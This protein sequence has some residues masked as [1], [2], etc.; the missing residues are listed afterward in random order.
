MFDPVAHLAHRQHITSPTLTRA[1]AGNEAAERLA[2]SKA[3]YEDYRPYWQDLER[4]YAEAGANYRTALEPE[5]FLA[6]DIMKG[7]FRTYDNA[8]QCE[9][10]AIEIE[11]KAA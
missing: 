9:W 1:H 2:P 5:V 10:A 8:R 11:R 4:E 3:S 7:L 6:R